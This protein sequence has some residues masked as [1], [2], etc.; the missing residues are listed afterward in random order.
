MS[1]PV[2]LAGAAAADI[3]PAMGM[4][5]AGDIGRPRPVEVIKDRLA[6]HAL[7]LECGEQKACLLSLDLL[8]STEP[9]A[10]RL[11]QAVGELLGCSMEAVMLHVTQTHSA[12]SLGHCFWR[13]QYCEP[14]RETM[15]WLSGGDEAYNPL[16]MQATLDAVR[17][18]LARR[19]P[20]TMSKASV[21]DGRVAFNRRCKLRDGTAR[22]GRPGAQEAPL[23]QVEG[24]AD[25]EVG[26]ALLTG[27]DGV[28]EA[29]LLHHT[30]HPTHGYP[31]REVSADWPGTWRRALQA[32][33]GSAIPLVINGCC[34]NVGPNNLLDPNHRANQDRMGELLAESTR[35]ALS[36]LAPL[37][38]APLRCLSRTLQLPL[39]P[40]DP[41]QLELDHKLLKEHPTPKMRTDVPGAVEWDWIYSYGRMDLADLQAQCMLYPYEIQ[42]LRIGDLSIVGLMGEPFVEAQLEIKRRLPTMHGF[43]AHF[44]NG[45]VGYLPT[46]AAIAGGGY[47]SR[48]G[49]WSRFAAPALQQV[50]D[51]S[52]TL[53]NGLWQ[54]GSVQH[55]A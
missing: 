38:G 1:T 34:G 35:L 31:T 27:T 3:T 41:A 50:I 21:V 18:A 12:P 55:K 29:A 51:N 45:Y 10:S 20:V 33:L 28:H 48:P 37:A 24:P 15:D 23:L 52:A 43:V 46:A 25:P 22:M 9:W 17:R 42:V 7:V 6:V 49:N 2:L 13:P 54:A 40:L 14:F 36:K 53:A 16:V 8:A 44:C 30:C 5:L 47:E 32:E 19:R 4:Q 39:R 11:R 26:V